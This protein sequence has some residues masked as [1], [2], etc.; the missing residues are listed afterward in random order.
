MSLIKTMRPLGPLIVAIALCLPESSYGGVIF[1]ASAAGQPVAQGTP[2]TVTVSASGSDVIGGVD[3]TLVWD[4]SVLTWQ[5]DSLSAP[6]S[7]GGALTD[8]AH[9]AN[10]G[11]T[12]MGMGLTWFNA[13]SP[14]QLTS[15]PVPVFTVTFDPI[16][17]PGTYTGEV[18]FGNGPPT[19]IEIDNGS[20]IPY[21]PSSLTFT[22]ADVQITPVPEPITTALTLFACLLFGFHAPRWLSR[23]SLIGEN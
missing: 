8:S 21:S 23:R 12:E 22:A 11:G 18:G 10:R 9:F 6:F 5:S 20:G 1:T 4:S 16:G 13:S 14:V 17:P 7:T 15:T 3:F 2:F 19:N